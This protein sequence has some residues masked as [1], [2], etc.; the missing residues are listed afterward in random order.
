MDNS[1]NKELVTL[2]GHTERVAI[3]NSMSELRP[4]M[5]GIPQG[6]IL[7]LMLFNFSVDDMACGIGIKCTLSKFADKPRS[8]V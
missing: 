2:N 5:T 3:N 6:L 7:G 1:V 4:E 8:V